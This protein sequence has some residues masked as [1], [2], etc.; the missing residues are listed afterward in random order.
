MYISHVKIRGFRS[1]Q[2]LDVNLTDYNTLIGKN[3]SGKSSFLLALQKLFDHE[4]MLSNEDVCL[5]AGHDGACSIEATLQ[6]CDHA[7]ATG[8][9]L[10]IRRTLTGQW[11]YRG[12]IPDN[13]LLKKMS[14]GSTFRQNING[15][16]TLPQPA[17]AFVQQV[18]VE[19]CPQGHVN[20]DQAK[21]I[22]R[23]TEE[24]GHVNLIAGW[25]NLDP[26][27][28]PTI[29]QVVSLT[30]SVRGE[31]EMMD[32]GRSVLN[33]VAGVL[34]REA[35]AGHDGINNALANLDQEIKN[36][37]EKVDN[38]WPIPE[39]N[40]F[41]QFLGEEIQRFDNT[42][43]AHPEIVPPQM[44]LPTFG[45]KVELTDGF[46]NQLEKM[47]HGFRRSVVF[48]MLRTHRRLKMQNAAQ[49]GVGGFS[50]LYLFLIEEPEL[51]LHPQ[52]ERRRLDELKELAGDV[53]SQVV[54]CTHSAIFVDM[55]NYQGI[56]RFERPNRQ[57]TKV[58][59]WSGVPPPQ[60]D[61][62][63]ISQFC[64]I[65]AYSAAMMFADLVILVEGVSEQ[66]ALPHLANK[67]DLHPPG[68]DVEVVSCDGN[69]KIPPLQLLLEGLGI[70]Y[71]AWLD[72]SNH[73]D[74]EEVKK[75]KKNRGAYGKIV[76][77]E[78]DWEKMNKL[79]GNNKIYDS[80]KHFIQ[81]DGDVNEKLLARL[82]AA[83]NWQ[84]YEGEAGRKRR[85]YIDVLSKLSSNR[86]R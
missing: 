61:A 12:Q 43:T 77:T 2:E 20:A 65:N 52:A 47:G 31:E 50:P 57:A 25:K 23:R 35:T 42:V 46:V 17:R 62:R 15:D 51:Y 66:A 73:E 56:H 21:E 8:H 45:V 60:D 32:G 24:A 85:N 84:D 81:D 70:Q 86:N 82:T 83:Y 49:A 19:E 74:K 18:L 6:D 29:V 54:L 9:A 1:L 33:R 75:A 14:E 41:E 58:I 59:S 80:W 7:F 63:A 36:V 34:V 3:D 26:H 5:I 64:R 38:Q 28:L 55:T 53:N 79:K 72:T 40:Q 76:T 68:R 10:T 30:A 37:S 69:S 27:V 39:L 78:L 48:A 71:V 13:D 22:Y 44:P 16:T 11:E 4:Q 67:H